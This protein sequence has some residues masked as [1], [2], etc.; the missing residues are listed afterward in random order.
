MFLLRM[1]E[2]QE[3]ILKHAKSGLEVILIILIISFF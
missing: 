1:T 3:Q 2:I